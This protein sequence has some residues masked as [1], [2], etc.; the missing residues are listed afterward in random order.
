MCNRTNLVSIVFFVAL[1]LVITGCSSD[2]NPNAPSSVS[3][4]ITYKGNPVPAGSVTFHS[5]EK[6]NYNA[7][8]GSDG[9][10]QIIDLPADTMI[11]TV[12]TES[13]NPKKKAPEYGGGKG[14]DD[15]KKRLAIE[16][17]MKQTVQEYVKIPTK[18]SSPKT[19]PITITLDRGRQ[20]KD[21]EL[22][23]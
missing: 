19:S 13:A 5:K 10:Y 11:V 8:L 15:Y 22:T 16:K 20:L 12:E 17:P 7:E 21:F 9:T 3:G 6:G 14:A 4:R 1:F 18:Y 23:D 2:R